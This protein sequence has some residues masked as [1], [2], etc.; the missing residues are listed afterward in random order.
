MGEFFVCDGHRVVDEDDGWLRPDALGGFRIIR[1]ASPDVVDSDECECAAADINQLVLVAQHLYPHALQ[2][3]TDLIGVFVVVFSAVPVL[4][5]VV[6]EY[7]LDPVLRLQLGEIVYLLPGFSLAFDNISSEE[8]DIRLLG[9][10]SVYEAGEEFGVVIGRLGIGD[11]DGLYRG[12]GGIEE[13][14][15][16]L[17]DFYRIGFY[18]ERGEEQ[19]RQ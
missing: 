9:V 12:G 1:A 2:L 6:A 16:V 17:G 8:Y 19:G 14:E 15:V 4:V 10:D 11:E 18:E 5:V 7:G 13:S 3:C